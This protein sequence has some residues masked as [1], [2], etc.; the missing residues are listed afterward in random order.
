M[1][2]GDCVSK[3]REYWRSGWE[4]VRRE[5]IERK[6]VTLPKEIIQAFGLIEERD[7]VTGGEIWTQGEEDILFRL[8]WE[9]WRI[10]E[11]ETVGPYIH[12][13]FP[14]VRTWSRSRRTYCQPELRDWTYHVC[15]RWEMSWLSKKNPHR[16][17]PCL[18]PPRE[19]STS[20]THIP[21]VDNH[22]Y[23]AR[24]IL[25]ENLMTPSWCSEWVL[26][27]HWGSTISTGIQWVSPYLH[28]MVTVKLVSKTNKAR[29][30]MT[31]PQPDTR[32]VPTLNVKRQ[33]FEFRN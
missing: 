25:A 31:H 18:L 11:R 20:R 27:K 1:A 23:V 24:G 5:C 22:G 10:E 26:W 29:L 17:N 9:N 32:S 33:S 21:S 15:V 13:K 2:N 14:S 30:D 8:D 19:N 4:M 12:G 28:R 3:D 7:E 6:M 16:A